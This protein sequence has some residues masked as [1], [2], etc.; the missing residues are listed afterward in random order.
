MDC[1]ISCFREDKNALSKLCEAVKTNFN[2]RFDEVSYMFKG[3][4]T[5]Y[6]KLETQ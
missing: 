4:V 3:R 5:I 2:D 1:V 6:V